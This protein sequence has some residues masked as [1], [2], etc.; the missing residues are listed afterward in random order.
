MARDT[1]FQPAAGNNAGLLS[2]AQ[3]QTH[4]MHAQSEGCG[5]QSS[6]GGPWKELG[7]T[8]AQPTSHQVQWGLSGSP[9]RRATRASV[10]WGDQSCGSGVHNLEDANAAAGP[11]ILG[12]AEQTDSC[13]GGGSRVA[14]QA[15][16]HLY[17]PACSGRGG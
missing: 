2:Q 7:S 12:W 11:A 15:F 17:K 3:L 16:Q 5:G 6:L 13:P 9:T 8:E 14:F 4:M 1:S 10:L